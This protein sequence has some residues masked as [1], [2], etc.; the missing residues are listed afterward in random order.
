MLTRKIDVGEDEIMEEDWW[1]HSKDIVLTTGYWLVLEG[2]LAIRKDGGEIV[3]TISK[4]LIEEVK[5]FLLEPSAKIC[6]ASIVADKKRGIGF[7]PMDE[8]TSKNQRRLLMR[9]EFE[10]LKKEKDSLCYPISIRF[11]NWD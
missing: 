6:S 8:K 2:G 11:L 9:K 10:E 7:S 1:K 3:M 5:E 4:T